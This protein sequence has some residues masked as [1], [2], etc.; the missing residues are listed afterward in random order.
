MA[1][2][3]QP[4][5]VKGRSKRGRRAVPAKEPLPSPKPRRPRTPNSRKSAPKVPT[6]KPV[7][8]DEPSPPSGVEPMP[9]DPEGRDP[10]VFST[11]TPGPDDGFAGF[12]VS[13]NVPDGTGAD[14]E[15][16][17]V[18][19]AYNTYLDVSTDRGLTFKRYDPRTIF[20]TPLGAGHQRRPGDSP[21]TSRRPLR[22][23]HAAREVGL[24]R[25]R[26]S[27]RGGDD[28]ATSRATR[29]PR[30]RAST[31]SPATSATTPRT[32]TTPTSPPAPSFLHVGTDVFAAP[33]SAGAKPKAVGRLVF[34][35]PLSDLTTGS[36]GFT[37]TK[38][39]DVNGSLKAKFAQGSTAGALWSG[40]KDN[41]TLRIW[42]W[43]GLRPPRGRA[44]TTSAWRRGRTSPPTS[45]PSRPTAPPTGSRT[46]PTSIR[47]K[48]IGAARS[49]DDVWLAW[50]AGK[51]DGGAGGF[52]FP[53]PHVRVAQV[54]T[55]NWTLKSEMQVWNRNHAFAY[56]VLNVN[57][58]GEIAL[59]VGFGG[60]PMNPD[61]AFG[62][63]GDFVVWFVNGSDRALTRWGDY[64]AI[65]RDGRSDV[66]VRRLRLLHDEDD[67]AH[68]RLPVQPLLRPVRPQVGLALPRQTSPRG[69]CACTS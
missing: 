22:V 56:P 53:H 52:S 38:I 49:G 44:P 5:V 34:R 42:E 43:R 54:D 25:G 15:I 14:S 20:T 51:G 47:N 23:V 63:I 13:D 59:G 69:G 65:R 21:R 8:L 35:I 57:G 16:G 27:P 7:P 37:Y 67:Q 62:I 60:P 6:G 40:H 10:V 31:S 61:S 32:S 55:T 4:E 17:V 36:I 11:Y 24:G 58:T 39:T 45:P 29:P 3:R 66:A 30:G 18:L 12:A 28:G 9:N 68:R 26:V 41:S 19:R 64:L 46:S 33:A 48:V 50:T 2:E 1:D